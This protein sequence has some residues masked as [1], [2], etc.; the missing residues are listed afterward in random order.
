M[1]QHFEFRRLNCR[2]SSLSTTTL[3]FQPTYTRLTISH[4]EISKFSGPI[5]DNHERGFTTAQ[6]V[7]DWAATSR[8]FDPHWLLPAMKSLKFKGER[9]VHN[10]F[11][12][13][14]DSLIA[15]EE[16][17][18]RLDVHAIQ[19]EALALFGRRKEFDDAVR[20]KYLFRETK[21][22]FGGNLVKEWAGL[23]Y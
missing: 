15:S 18:K 11:L 22:V 17:K 10:E 21:K 23:G 7:S 5:R 13:H 14:L 2:V 1:D 4:L 20:E 3:T 12:E 8:F 6:E 16:S 19:D 9:V